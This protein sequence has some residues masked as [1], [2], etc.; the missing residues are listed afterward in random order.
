[1]MA[2]WLVVIVMVWLWPKRYGKDMDGAVDP[3]DVK[4]RWVRQ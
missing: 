2:Q 4:E 3:Y 1:M